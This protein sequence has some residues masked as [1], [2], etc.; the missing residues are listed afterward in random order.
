MQTFVVRVWTPGEE[1]AP[2]GFRGVCEHIGSGRQQ[3]FPSP[4]VLLS[5][6][7]ETLNGDGAAAAKPSKVAAAD[8]EA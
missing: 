7:A 8:G 1:G 6:I 2:D 4:E 3:V 5:F